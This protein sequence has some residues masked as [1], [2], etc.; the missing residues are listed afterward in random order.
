MGQMQKIEDGITS[1]K[2][3][4]E[5]ELKQ[6]ERDEDYRNK[7]NRMNDKI[8]ENGINH[9]GY[10]QNNT[11]SPIKEPFHIKNDF[12]FNKRL[13]NLKANERDLM[14]NDQ[15]ELNDRLRKVL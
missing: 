2:Q 8:Y 10:I 13:A 14:K 1:R 5:R 12:E 3:I 11:N 15:N 7:L 6:K 9:G 4:E